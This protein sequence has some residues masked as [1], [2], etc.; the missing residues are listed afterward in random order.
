MT[1]PY[2][3]AEVV[4]P[5]TATVRQGVL[6]LRDQVIANRAHVADQKAKIGAQVADLTAELDALD[7]VAEVLDRDKATYEAMLAEDEQPEVPPDEEF[8]GPQTGVM[9]KVPAA[10]LADVNGGGPS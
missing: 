3:A 9:A 1:H 4:P 6:S 8:A 10:A 7:R 2:S 5:L